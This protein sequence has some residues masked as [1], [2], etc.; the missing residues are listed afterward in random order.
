MVNHFTNGGSRIPNQ[1][2]LQSLRESETADWQAQTDGILI[3]L[4]YQIYLK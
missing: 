4:K 2:E 3:Y 1:V